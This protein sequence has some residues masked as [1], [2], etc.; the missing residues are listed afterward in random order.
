MLSSLLALT[1]LTLLVAA[2]ARQISKHASSK[3]YMGSLYATRLHGSPP[4][5]HLPRIKNGLDLGFSTNNGYQFKRCEDVVIAK[6][7]LSYNADT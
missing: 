3:G 7:A 1:S 2:A 6:K 4:F 5:N